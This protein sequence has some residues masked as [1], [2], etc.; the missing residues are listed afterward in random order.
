MT[1]GLGEARAM[2]AAIVIGVIAGFIGFL[3]LFAS[4]RLARKHPSVSVANAALYGLG[5]TFVSLVVVAVA[6]IVCALVAR[7][8]A[9]PFGMAEIVSLIVCTAVYVWRKNVA[10]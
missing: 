6:L 4:L 9:L 3:P 2:V 5:G 1:K 8:M 7:P 10:R